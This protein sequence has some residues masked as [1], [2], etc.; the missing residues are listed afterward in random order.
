MSGWGFCGAFCLLVNVSLF[1]WVRFCLFLGLVYGFVLL[2]LLGFFGGRGL[3]GGGGFRCMGLL[4]CILL[5]CLFVLYFL[6]LIL[7]EILRGEQK[8]SSIFS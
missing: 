3:W 7:R 5:V 8:S 4:C 6:F 1:W 2:F